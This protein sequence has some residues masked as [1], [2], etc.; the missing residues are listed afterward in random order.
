MKTLAFS[1]P[2]VSQH[3]WALAVLLALVAALA[4]VRRDPVEIHGAEITPEVK[5]GQMLRVTRYGKFLRSDCNRT[6]SMW[7][8][9][10][11]GTPWPR[12]AEMTGR[13]I[14]QTPTISRE[15]PVP[16]SASWG[17][18]R[19]LQQISYACFPFGEFWP[20]VVDLPELTFVIVP[21]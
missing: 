17:K 16:Y 3:V 18:A 10:S 4:W 13:A 6:V 21:P 11:Q 20:I 7:I 8:V 5:A 14:A 1:R 15:I 12:V 2:M 19:Y 9:D